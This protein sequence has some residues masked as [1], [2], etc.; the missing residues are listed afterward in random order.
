MPLIKRIL[1]LAGQTVSR[2]SLIVA[3]DGMQLGAARECD[4]RG[5]SLPNWQGC[6]SIG[7]GEVF[8]MNLD[9]P[10]S[11]DG[12]YFGVLPASS[13]IGRAAPPWTFE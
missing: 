9:A 10:A 8:L 1:A 4:S 3:V 2:T 6:V 13:I 12:R 7:D 5:R 11:L